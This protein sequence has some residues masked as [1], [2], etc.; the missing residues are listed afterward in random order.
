MYITDGT[1]TLLIVHVGLGS[2]LFYLRRVATRS[3]YEMI[4]TC[5][6]DAGIEKS[7][8]PASRRA[9]KSFRIHFRSQCDTSK[10]D[11]NPALEYMCC[12]LVAIV[13]LS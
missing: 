11:V 8:I 2:H 5:V 7:S 9:S 6:H 3:A 13:F 10:K 1:C 4:W 12:M